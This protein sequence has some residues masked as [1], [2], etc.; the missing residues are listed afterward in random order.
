MASQKK[1]NRK[2]SNS[3]SKKTGGGFSLVES[4]KEESKGSK[5]RTKNKKRPVFLTLLLAIFVLFGAGGYF[6]FRQI[7]KND[8]FTLVG[9]KE[10]VLSVGEV[11]QEKGA[12]VISFGKD[13]SAQVVIESN[14]DTSVAGRYYVKYQVKDFRFKSVVRYRYVIVEEVG[15]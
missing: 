11:Y 9:E 10:V 15:A 6:T 2:K 7:T 14:V 12:K 1:T 13:K 3:S 4:F 8:E 5:K